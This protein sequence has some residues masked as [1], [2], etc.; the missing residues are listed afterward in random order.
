[1]YIIEDLLPEVSETRH[2]NYRLRSN[3]EPCLAVLATEP[4]LR[5][6][7]SDSISIAELKIKDPHGERSCDSM[8]HVEK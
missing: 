1:M 6:D 4:A 2:E 5:A 3:L 8:G 7:H